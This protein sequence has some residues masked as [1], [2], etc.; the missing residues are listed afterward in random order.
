V[1]VAQG[2]GPAPGAES[3]T[4]VPGAYQLVSQTLYGSAQPNTDSPQVGD[5]VRR[6]L[7]VDCDV[8]YELYSQSAADGSSAAGNYCR[9]LDPHP[10]SVLSV[11]GIMGPGIT[12]LRDH[13]A[14]TA[15][16]QHLILIEL[17]PYTDGTPFNIVG[18][19]TYVSD[20][21]LVGGS[22][23][24]APA[25]T[26]GSGP[27]APTPPGRDPRCPAVP[28]SDGAPCSSDGSPIE[29][30]YG[31]DMFGRCTTL[32]E[33]VLS[34]TEQTYQFRITPPGDCTPP[35]P[36]EC[37]PTFAAAAAV[38]AQNPSGMSPTCNYAEGACGCVIRLGGPML[39]G[40]QPCKWMCRNGMSDSWLDP[41]CPWPRPL[42][43]DACTAGLHC[44]YAG[45]CSGEPLLG[46]DM[47]CQQGHWLQVS[48]E[49][50]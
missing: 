31:G 42:A 30:E 3:G 50:H 23:S 48:Y 38:A 36:K 9:R 49:C 19:Y 47:I 18:S 13:V 6:V 26:T 41:G 37:P 29:C 20:F 28:P 22:A 27:T 39:P 10:P 12:D 14:Y 5:R 32:A 45:A 24:S 7:S 21:A 46:P 44:D 1:I 8:A 16:A 17:Y 35:N 33:C 43:G 34:L 11:S 2:M 4:I 40:A 15:R 25:S